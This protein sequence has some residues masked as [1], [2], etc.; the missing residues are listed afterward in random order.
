MVAILEMP[1]QIETDDASICVSIRIQQAFL[2]YYGRKHVTDKSYNPTG[3]AVVQRASLT[4]KEMLN[5]NG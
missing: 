3:Q 1:L 4:L 5:K 2:R